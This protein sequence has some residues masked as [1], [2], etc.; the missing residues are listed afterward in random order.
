MGDLPIADVIELEQLLGPLRHRHDPG[1]HRR[2]DRRLHPR[3]DLQRLRRHL[4]PRRLPGPG[5]AAPKGL[6]LT[7]TPVL[8]LDGDTGTGQQTLCFVDQTDPRHAHRLL[9]RHVP[10]DAPRGGGSHTRAMTFLRRSGARD[11]GEAARPDPARSPRP[12]PTSR[13]RVVELDDFKAA[14]DDWLDAHEGELA[15][16]VRG[17]RDARP[18]DGAAAQGDAADLR[19]RL[20]A[21]GL[22][23]ARRR[24]RRIDPPAR[25]PRRGC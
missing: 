23:R 7:G 16:D 20:H 22:A 6:F 10:A 4:R 21:H 3:R 2:G 1:R 25:L 12:R 18:A 9:H 5:R 24:A 17:H 15:P 8:E 11:S 13:A 14:V 19:R